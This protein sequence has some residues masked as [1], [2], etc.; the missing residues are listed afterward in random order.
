V[1]WY[2]IQPW[3]LPI[4]V[5]IAIVVL[6]FVGDIVLRT[7]TSPEVRRNIRTVGLA[8]LAVLTVVIAVMAIGTSTADSLSSIGAFILAA[9]TLVLSIRSY[10]SP[11]PEPEPVTS[12]PVKSGPATAG[13]DERKSDDQVS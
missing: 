3:Q 9:V 12:E 13:P 4:F 7:S 6:E 2:G 11:R 10:L 5:T 8:L 1:T